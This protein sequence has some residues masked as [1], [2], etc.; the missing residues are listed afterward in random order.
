MIRMNLVSEQK[1]T[2]RLWKRTCGYQKRSVWA[3]AWVCGTGICT[4]RSMEWLANGD[5]FHSTGNAM[6]YS[7][8]IYVGNESDKL[9]RLYMYSWIT[10]LYSR[11]CHN[12]VHQLCFHKTLKVKKKK[13]IPKHNTS[14]MS[15]HTLPPLGWIFIFFTHAFGLNPWKLMWKAQKSGHRSGLPH[16]PMTATVSSLMSNA[17][18]DRSLPSWGTFD[19]R[20][21]GRKPQAGWSMW[22]TLSRWRGCRGA[23]RWSSA[24]SRSKATSSN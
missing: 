11:N 8:I 23:G 5:L 15:P 19:K 12:M 7:L 1:Q 17:S 10:L 13:K 22:T 6:Q 9:W 2:H 16:S 4:P 14:A 20:L 24:M 21:S 18:V 3:M